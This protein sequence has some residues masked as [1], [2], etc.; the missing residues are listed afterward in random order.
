MAKIQLI[1][2]ADDADDLAN[3]L[4]SLSDALNGESEGSDGADAPE[5]PV[6]GRP[7]GSRKAQATVAS[8][9]TTPSGDQGVSQE[10]GG[11]APG[12]TAT[13]A[14]SP[15]EGGITKEAVGVKMQAAMEASTP[16]KL[17]EALEKAGLP[18]RLSEI[19]ADKYADAISVFEGIIALA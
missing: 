8:S 13:T 11:P 4:A 15:S 7:R 6:R 19:P 2:D 16:L 1:I 9:V 17:Q 12:P 14:A 10:S 5:K 18:K 3:T